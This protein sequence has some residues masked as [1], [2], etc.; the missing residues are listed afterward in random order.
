M[1][2]KMLEQYDDNVGELEKSL[3]GRGSNITLNHC[4]QKKL[5]KIISN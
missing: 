1:F 3:K 5:I 2:F 4:T